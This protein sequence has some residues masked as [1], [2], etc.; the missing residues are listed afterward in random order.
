MNPSNLNR[1]YAPTPPWTLIDVVED[2]ETPYIPTYRYGKSHGS[3]CIRKL[4]GTKMRNTQGLMDEF[5][6]VFQFFNGFAENWNA[7]QECLMYLDEVIKA[8]TYIAVIID[9]KEVLVEENSRQLR[10]LC[11]TL[12]DV[13]EWWSKPIED[14]AVFNRPAIPF[15][16][17]LQCKR[18]DLGE[19][20]KRFEGV[21]TLGE[22]D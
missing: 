20:R 12:K 21:P 22:L 16:F 11:L 4:R 2:D 9:P 1:L 17:V 3:A 5:G 13:G 19:T 18:H 15:H 10:W 7:L 6:A 8:D 14:N